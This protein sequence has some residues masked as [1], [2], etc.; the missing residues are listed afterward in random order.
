[1]P[2]SYG[3]CAKRVVICTL[4]APDNRVVGVGRNDCRTAQPTCPRLPGEGYAKCRLICNQPAH[5]EVAALMA[6]GK[7]ARGATAWIEG[8][9]AICGDCLQAL[10][11]AGV[12]RV[13]V[14]AEHRNLQAELEGSLTHLSQ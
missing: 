2:F 4:V 7:A 5:A 11:R 1:M 6:A 14:R 12:A 10:A 8:I 3:P 13:E 9:D